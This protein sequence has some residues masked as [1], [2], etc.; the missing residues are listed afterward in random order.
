MKKKHIIKF[1]TILVFGSASLLLLL[2]RLDWIDLPENSENQLQRSKNNMLK[3]AKNI[4][5][6]T[7]RK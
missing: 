2:T 1:L 7:K 6:K 3:N 5:Q 4:I